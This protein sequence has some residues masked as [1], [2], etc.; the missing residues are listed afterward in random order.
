M[1]FKFVI[2]LVV[3]FLALASICLVFKLNIILF[4]ILL[5]LL[6]GILRLCNTSFYRRL[7]IFAFLFG[8]IGEWLCCRVNLWVYANPTWQGLPVWLPLIWP[9]LM[10]SFWQLS[11]IV[12]KLFQNHLRIALLMQAVGWL[13]IVVYSIFCF[14]N[15][16]KAIA[17][18]YLIFSLG[19]LI[20]GRSRQFLLYFLI[21]AIGGAFG[22]IIC[23]R[24]DVWY[25]THPFFL[26]LGIP[27]S[28][29]LAWGL[30]AV[31]IAL[32]AGGNKK[33]V[34]LNS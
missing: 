6:I 13:L 25:Y 11:L 10:L 8:S 34:S 23:M 9:I 1:L 19:F 4:F 21:S 22:E 27:L 16:D 5:G 2:P 29:P 33:P 15:I 17:S 28:L 12:D 14:L 24:F 18:V 31:T 32:L 30:S 3:D 26:K 20:W 7:A